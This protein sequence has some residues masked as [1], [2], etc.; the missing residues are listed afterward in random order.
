MNARRTRTLHAP[1]RAAAGLLLA[2]LLVA[3]CHG[4]E[5]APVGVGAPLPV[6]KLERLEGGTISSAQW[7]GRTVVLNLWATWCAPCRR[8]MP[9]LQALSNRLDPDRFQVVGL[10]LDD[11]RNLVREFA[12]QHAITFPLAVDPAGYTAHAVLGS[13]VLPDTFV[14]APD[15]RLVDRVRGSAPW[16]SDAM[17]QRVLAT[18]SP[19]PAPV[20]VAERGAPVRR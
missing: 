5:P 15:G 7:R 20:V 8:E 13:R 1:A 14:V 4:S 19:G 12:L 10:A 9:A 6:L 16:D 11:D 17:R 2:A 18:Q 3:G